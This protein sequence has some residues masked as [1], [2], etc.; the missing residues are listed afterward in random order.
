MA[1]DQA[2]DVIKLRGPVT[3]K[4]K[5]FID[6]KAENAPFPG[7]DRLTKGLADSPYTPPCKAIGSLPR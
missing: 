6:N 5:L 7:S 1:L 3:L 2:K 4:S